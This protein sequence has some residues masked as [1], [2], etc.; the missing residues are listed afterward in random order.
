M[1]DRLLDKYT[2]RRATADDDTDGGFEVD[3]GSEDLGAFGWLRGPRER[4][5]MLELRKK[6]GAIVAVAYGFINRVEFN[7]SQGIILRCGQEKILIKG[8]GL[9]AEIRPQI[10]LFQGLTRHRVPWI[11][12][13]DPATLLRANKSAVVVEAFEC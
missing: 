2:G 5:V 8:R 11:Q 4:A 6:D 3:G 7:P 1:S 12:E 9:N 10:R 13:A